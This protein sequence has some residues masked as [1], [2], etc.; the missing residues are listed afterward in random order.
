MNGDFAS[1]GM[2]GMGG[3]FGRGDDG[4]DP[5]REAF[6]KRE[7][8][9]DSYLDRLKALLTPEQ[10]EA[11]P[12]PQRG[13][14]GGGGAG[15]GVTAMLD[16]LPAEQREAILKAADKNGNG[17]IDDDERGDAFRAMR[18]LGGFGGGG[19]GGDQGGGRGPGGN[20]G[21]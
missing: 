8:V 6:D 10:V 13:G 5:V 7:R 18:D 16:R 2:G 9:E 14:R 4:P 3:M 12:K 15:G 21:N 20:A 17:Q 19:R 11:L 1:M